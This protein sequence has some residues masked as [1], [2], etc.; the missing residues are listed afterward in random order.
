MIANVATWKLAAQGLAACGALGFTAL[1]MF[2]ADSATKP[3]PL[4]A[5]A[6][7]HHRRSAAIEPTT[8]T[9]ELPAEMTTGDGSLGSGSGFSGDTSSGGSSGFASSDIGAPPTT[10]Q[11]AT[12]PP[13][14]DSGPPPTVAETE[15]PVALPISAA[16]MVGVGVGVV[17]VSRRRRRNNGD[18]RS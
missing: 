11:P 12:D 17:A 13:V 5:P 3:R 2:G 18:T 6:V 8:A 16:V 10:G 9:T 4:P 14:T 1:T 15:F 7:T